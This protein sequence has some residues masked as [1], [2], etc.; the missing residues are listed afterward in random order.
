M[1]RNMTSIYP[2]ADVDLLPEAGTQPTITPR[3]VI[4]HTN[5]GTNSATPS[6]LRAYLGRPDVTLEAHFDVGLDGA[7]LQM[8]PVHVR[9]D[10]NYRA[11]PFAVSIETQ[12][13]GSNHTPLN[14]D[15]WTPAQQTAIVNLLRW[16]AVEWSIPLERALSWDG[17]GVGAHRDFPEWS[18][19]GHTCPGDAR[20][21]QVADLIAR[22]RGGITP[23]PPPSAR[24][25]DVTSKWVREAGTAD[26]V[27]EIV[28]DAGYTWTFQVGGPDDPGAHNELLAGLFYDPSTLVEWPG[29][30]LRNA[31]HRPAV[32]TSV[33]IAS[34]VVVHLSGNVSGELSG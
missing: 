9:A 24:L 27:W 28:H 11:N 2:A 29:E 23:P 25:D 31:P 34:P 14:F 19:A 16:L 26:T 5:G 6:Q 15:P 3:L 22:A 18:A 7:V 30:Q 21:A 12:D 20:A 32:V 13:H 10:A 33:G 17:S 1:G 8:M 4:L